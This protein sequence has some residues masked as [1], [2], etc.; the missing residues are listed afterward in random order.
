M[1]VSFI[2]G[3]ILRTATPIILVFNCSLSVLS[4]PH[5]ASSD[6]HETLFFQLGNEMHRCHTLASIIGVLIFRTSSFQSLINA[7]AM[8]VFLSLTLLVSQQDTGSAWYQAWHIE[9]REGM[10]RMEGRGSE[11]KQRSELIEMVWKGFGAVLVL[12]GSME[13][14]YNWLKICSC[15]TL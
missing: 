2:M 6:S 11:Y 15:H 10:R 9:V 1:R 12:W 14:N 13:V 3:V 8:L 5:T 7:A 4:L